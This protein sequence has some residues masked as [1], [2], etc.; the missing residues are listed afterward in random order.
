MT[1]RRKRRSTDI[2]PDTVPPTPPGSPNQAAPGSHITHKGKTNTGEL[3]SD[4]EYM[5]SSSAESTQSQEWYTTWFCTSCQVFGIEGEYC[6]KCSYDSGERD[7]EVFRDVQAQHTNTKTDVSVTWP[8]PVQSPMVKCLHCARM[9]HREGQCEFCHPS[10]QAP[11]KD[12]HL[13]KNDTHTH[14]ITH[15]LTMESWTCGVCYRQVTGESNLCDWC[16]ANTFPSL[17]T[18]ELQQ[19]FIDKILRPMPTKCMYCGGKFNRNAE[20]D[21]CYTRVADLPLHL[22]GQ[23]LSLL[24][25]QADWINEKT[26]N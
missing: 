14:D 22:Q 7:L 16:F 3:L 21:A 13:S 4:L 20:C 23:M 24:E 15:Y 10:G 9:F 6:Q 18:H 11:T 19:K 1:T 12:N 26:A 17:P 25:V 8:T 5:P 2:T